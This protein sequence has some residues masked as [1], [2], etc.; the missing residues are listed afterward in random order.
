MSIWTKLGQPAQIAGLRLQNRFVMA[1]MTR[2]QCPGGIPTDLVADYYGRRA[3]QLGLIVTEGVYVDDPSAGVSADVPRLDSPKALAGWRKVIAQ[4]HEQGAKIF[5]QL[6]HI[7]SVRRAGA[8]PFPEAPVV[9]PSGLSLRGKHIGEPATL[10]QIDQ[11]IDG[12]ASSAKTA[13]EI[14]FDGVEIHGA[15][16]YLLDQFHWA[17]T[18]KRSDQF[19][20]T[21]EDRIRLSIDVVTEIRRR[22]GEGFPIQFRFSQWK[23]GSFDAQIADTPKELESILVPLVEAGVDIFHPSTRRFWLPAFEGSDLT[24][25]GWTKR[26]THK[27]AIAVGH[28]GVPTPFGEDVVSKEVYRDED[29][30]ALYDRGEFDLLAIGRAILADPEWITKT[31]SGRRADIHTYSKESEDVFY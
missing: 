31:A 27:P 23:G 6:W 18:N 17:Q 29:L 28:V 16:G 1:P 25:A 21:L 24:L 5:P 10:K 13:K 12:F 3:G 7:G 26:L 11:V 4:A 22:V 14:G 15:H 19:G 2:S 30:E 8:A 9:S 20:G